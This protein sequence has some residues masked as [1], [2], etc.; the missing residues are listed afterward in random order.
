MLLTT[1]D[2]FPLY[3]ECEKK[4]MFDKNNF[5]DELPQLIKK[6]FPTSFYISLLELEEKI[7]IDSKNTN[8]LDEVM[9]YYSVLF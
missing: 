6:P 2:K 7:L 5:L 9:D 1:D 8:F 3:S 4:R